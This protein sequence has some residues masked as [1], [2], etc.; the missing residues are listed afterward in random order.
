MK[1]ART[2]TQRLHD[3]RPHELKAAPISI[4]GMRAGQWMLVPSAR[5]IDDF[6]RHI[7][8]GQSMDARQLRA[9]LAA[10]HGTEVCCPITTGF[11]L[12]T[13]AEAVGE[14]LAQGESI[15]RVTPVWRVL[16][17]GAPTWAKLSFDVSVL[18]RQRQLE[19]LDDTV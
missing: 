13:V 3:P 7:P 6:V 8:R 15:T 11:H 5:L 17:A 12:R 2:W 1:P 16:P 14:A 10:A 4:A 9:A 18:R 19:G